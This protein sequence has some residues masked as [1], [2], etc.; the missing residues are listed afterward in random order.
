M[1]KELCLSS[2]LIWSW[3][4]VIANNPA[5]SEYLSLILKKAIIELLLK[6]NCDT[7]HFS[8]CIRSWLIVKSFILSYIVMSNL[9]LTVD[10]T[11]QSVRTHFQSPQEEIL[12]IHHIFNWDI[13]KYIVKW[14]LSFHHVSKSIFKK[15]IKFS[16]YKYCMLYPLTCLTTKRIRYYWKR[17]DWGVLKETKFILMW[18]KHYNP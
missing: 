2:I 4:A 5:Y 9:Q 12:M 18:F 3:E 16:S 1:Y 7:R 17:E 6:Y 15:K 11:L 14:T 13:S 10:F 8:I